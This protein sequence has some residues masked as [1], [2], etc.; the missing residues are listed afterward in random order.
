MDPTRLAIAVVFGLAA[1]AWAIFWIPRMRQLKNR[2][3]ASQIQHATTFGEHRAH[4]LIR[5]LR[6]SPTH[7]ERVAFAI[8]MR[9]AYREKT[10]SRKLEDQAM[11]QVLDSYFDEV[12]RT[13][14][15]VGRK[16]R[17]FVQFGLVP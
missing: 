8:M 10:G 14:G 12:V 15:D 2:L 4:Q 17:D 13:N 16:F 1:I 7:E 11:L 6:G 3:N 9:K 5:G